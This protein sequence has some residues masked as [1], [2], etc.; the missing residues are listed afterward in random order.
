M[1]ITFEPEIAFPSDPYE[2]A[3]VYLGVMAYPE[4]GAGALNQPGSIFAN[5]LAQFSIW[6]CSKAKGLRYIRDQKGDPTYVA[7]KKREFRGAFDRGMRRVERRFAAY[8]LIGTQLLQGFFE[9]MR[10]GGK[11]IQEGK[12]H[13]AYHMHPTGGPSPARAELWEQGTP[14]I[15]RII[16]TAPGHWSRK[17]SLNRTGPTADRAQKV[18]DDYERAFLPSVPVLHMAH[19]FAECA[20]EIG[21]S[22][23][24]WDERDPI[25]A[26]L[27]NAE[28]WIWE[29]L[30]RAERWRLLSHHFPG[31]ISLEPSDMVKLI[32]PAEIPVQDLASLAAVGLDARL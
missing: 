10:L 25:T 17:L 4:R 12:A 13:E 16:S 2:A 15:R 7:P 29:A 23:N 5:A 26:M 11:A 32:A 27:L 24:D 8:D 28:L 1:R 14:S 19:G 6:A 22:I 21:P 31:M 20:R 30:V 9:V 3:F 18:K